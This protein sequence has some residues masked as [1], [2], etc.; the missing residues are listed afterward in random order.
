MACTD[1]AQ[2][3]S[4]SFSPSLLRTAPPSAQS[5]Y[6]PNGL[7]FRSGD[8]GLSS[9]AKVGDRQHSVLARIIA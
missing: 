9:P 2:P 4:I 3:E 6:L 5:A 8:R 7:S 1:L